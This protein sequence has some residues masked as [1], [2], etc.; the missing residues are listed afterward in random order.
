MGADEVGTLKGLTERRAIL[1]RL[2][3]EHR[4]RIANTA[5]DSVLAEFG[6]VVEAVQCAV[7]AQTALT[8]AN[9]GVLPDKHINFRIGIHIGDVMIRAG[10]LFGDGV[11]I[12]ARLQSIATPGGVCISGATY[13]QVRKVL[14][15]TFA[16]LGVQQVKNIQEPIR[17]Y[18]VGAP[19]ETREA[20][21][22]TR[23][24]ETES[25]PPLP[26]KP[27]IA[28]LPFQ[29]MSG[30]PEQ[31]YFAD[32]MVED[33]TTA[34]SRA[35][36]L[37]VIARNSSFTYKGRAVDAKQ[38]GRE[39]GVRYVL[40]GSVRKAGARLRITGQ[41]IDALT[42]THL[43][44]DRFDGSLEDVFELQDKVALSVAGVIE[45]ALQ[46]AEIRRATARPTS[47]LTA[48]DLY[49]RAWPLMRGWGKEPALQGLDLLREA[50][51]RDPNYGPAL[52]AASWCTS[53]LITGGWS[54]D[55]EIDR[56]EALDL[57]RRA[58]KAAPDD[59]EVLV[60]AA[61]T[62]DL[63]GED[64]GRSLAMLD[65][66]LTLNPSNAFGWFWSGFLRLFAGSTETAIEHFEKSLRL[67]PRT[68][69]RHF[70]DTGLGACYFLQRRFDEAAALLA[71]S[72]RQV[73]TYV[74]TAYF[75]ASCY[76]YMERLDDAGGILDHL[77]SIGSP[78]MP[79]PGL[80]LRDPT[81]REFW[82]S[83]LRRAARGAA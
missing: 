42:G 69:R 47:D 44:A 83:G 8:E 41:L 35:R 21:A 11:N 32:G 30:D 75:L 31:E 74:T 10:D 40:E 48:Y 27:S 6:S 37:F 14:P 29:N 3:E 76:A 70:H 1:D 77:R 12:A 80:G 9:T 81:Q 66:A 71:G 46:E 67:D 56:R 73:P 72:L 62:L 61:G 82:L 22:P 64:I 36:W 2:I 60:W 4:G 38:V 54:K 65:H 18:Q 20:A 28:V 59:P 68:P 25:G 5:G 55:S 43:W 79:P 52:V 78:P 50:I 51:A 33:I 49:L 23:V 24:S 13:D 45:P 7:E 57:V 63:L 26:D 16:D 58:I 17:A 39:L 15:L 19:S 34:L 53:Q